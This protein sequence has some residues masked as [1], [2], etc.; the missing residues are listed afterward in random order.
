MS[1]WTDEDQRALSLSADDIEGHADF[2]DIGSSLLISRAADELERLKKAVDQAYKDGYAIG[3]KHGAGKAALELRAEIQ[4][5][6]ERLRND[7]WG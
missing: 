4:A 7:G 3:K 1:D 5:L 2:P 6:E